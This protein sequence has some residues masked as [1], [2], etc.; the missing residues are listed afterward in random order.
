[1]GTGLR[2]P[3]RADAQRNLARVLDAAGRLFAE[4]GLDVGVA[5]I[6]RLAGVGTATVFRRFPHKE[7]LIVAVFE[8]RVDDMLVEARAAADEEPDAAA[9]LR[10]FMEA[11]IRL[12]LRDRGFGEAMSM[13]FVLHPRIR[14]RLGEVN[15]QIERMLTAAQ[16]A[17]SIRPDVDVFDIPVLHYATSRAAVLTLGA[18][19]DAWLRYVALVFD[20][21]RPEGATPLGADAPTREELELAFA[22][23]RADASR[24]AAPASGTS[25]S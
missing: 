7:D 16:R 4:R 1:M 6:A 19:P 2:E 20:G 13:H 12:Q 17:G 24:A 22:H 10:R 5:D 3:L 23:E 21:M 15:A 11:A 9:G 25:R 18:G 14:D 8:R